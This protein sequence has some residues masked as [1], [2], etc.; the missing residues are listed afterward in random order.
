MANA[1]IMCGQRY[2]EP[3]PYVPCCSAFC[4]FNRWRVATGADKLT[5]LE[6][7]KLKKKRRRN[8]LQC[9]RLQRSKVG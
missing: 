7:R 4:R 9:Q 6:Y 5:R 2:I 1:C 3:S 8:K